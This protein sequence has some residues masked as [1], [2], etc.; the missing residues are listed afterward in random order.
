MNKK[1]RWILALPAVTILI[2]VVTV[3]FVFLSMIDIALGKLVENNENKMPP[4]RKKRKEDR[5]D[6]P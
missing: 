2:A 5:E 6:V 3:L 1:K 4:L